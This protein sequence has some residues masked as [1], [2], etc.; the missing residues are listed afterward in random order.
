MVNFRKI[1]V[2]ACLLATPTSALSQTTNNENP[3]A[4]ALSSLDHGSVGFQQGGV[5][6]TAFTASFQKHATALKKSTEA[7][8]AQVPSGIRGN[9]EKVHT[10]VMGTIT[11]SE[12]IGFHKLAA[13]W[14]TGVMNAFK[15]HGIAL[16]ETA[17]ATYTQLPLEF[18]DEVKKAHA[19]IYE[20]EWKDLPV[21]IQD[22]IREHP[23]QSAFY[24]VN[25]VV[26]FAPAISS[27]PILW[28][29]GYAGKGERAA[30]FASMLHS[31]FGVVVAKNAR[32]YLQSAGM[33]GYGLGAVNMVARLSGAAGIVGGLVGWKVAARNGTTEL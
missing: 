8:Y 28:A 21:D 18:R 33:G 14:I 25:G 29:L 23:W 24:V 20:I 27:G 11:S 22:Y 4:Q 6:F 31:K 5:A 3:P 9:V 7:I 19:K 15:K 26:F 2:C 16:K 17:E 32:A 1:V 10:Q 12:V 30:S 13:E